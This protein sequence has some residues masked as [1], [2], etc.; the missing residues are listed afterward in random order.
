M[1]VPQIGVFIYNSCIP[2]CSIRLPSIGTLEVKVDTFLSR[3]SRLK[4]LVHTFL[5]GVRTYSFLVPFSELSTQ[6]T[7]YIVFMYVQ[8]RGLHRRGTQV[9]SIKRIQLYQF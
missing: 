9:G 1:T 7:G 6:R 2:I 4:E 8:T 5:D 3:K